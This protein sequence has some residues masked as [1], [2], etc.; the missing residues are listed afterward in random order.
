MKFFR[1]D[2]DFIKWQGITV[3]SYDESDNNKI[4]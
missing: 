1:T 4:E 2:P 3:K